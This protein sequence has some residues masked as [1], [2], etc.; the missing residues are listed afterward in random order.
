MC[1]FVFDFLDCFRT[2]AHFFSDG[3]VAFAIAETACYF[4]VGLVALDVLCVGLVEVVALCAVACLGHVQ[5]SALFDNLNLEHI[6]HTAH[7]I[8]LT[9]ESVRKLKALKSR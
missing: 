7:R 8:T 9:G 4:L 5:K 1:H 3:P 6:V 2:Y